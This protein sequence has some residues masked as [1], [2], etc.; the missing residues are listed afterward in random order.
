MIYGIAAAL[1]GT[2]LGAWL[3]QDAV[4]G[5]SRVWSAHILPAYDAVLASG[6]LGFCG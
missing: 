4:A 6:L 2:G 1:L 5:L 3:G